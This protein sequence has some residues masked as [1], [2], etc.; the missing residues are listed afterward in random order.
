MRSPWAVLSRMVGNIHMVQ[1]E[2]KSLVYFSSFIYP[3]LTVSPKSFHSVL[4]LF[5]LIKYFCLSKFD[6]FVWPVW[7]PIKISR[8][9]KRRRPRI[10]Q[11]FEQEAWISEQNHYKHWLR[12]EWKPETRKQLKLILPKTRWVKPWIYGPI[13]FVLVQSDGSRTIIVIEDMNSLANWTECPTVSADTLTDTMTIL[14]L[15]K[16]PDI[17]FTAHECARVQNL[18]V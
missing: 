3:S 10:F 6:Q 2:S 13:I 18:H 8:N 17:F 9:H 15:R 5:S 16:N 11:F 14:T 12:T 4:F 1:S 7:C